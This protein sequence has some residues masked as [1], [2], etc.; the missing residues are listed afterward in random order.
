MH[1][2]NMQRRTGRIWQTGSRSP[3]VKKSC[4]PKEILPADKNHLKAVNSNP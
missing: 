3:M 4:L 2:G 1:T